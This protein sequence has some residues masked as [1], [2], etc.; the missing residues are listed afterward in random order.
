M[1]LLRVSGSIDYLSCE[2]SC[3]TPSNWVTTT[4]TPPLG[5]LASLDYDQS[6]YFAVDAA[7]QAALV[8]SAVS[9]S[10]LDDGTYLSRCT[11][12]CTVAGNW[13]RTRLSTET[14]WF[15]PHL[16][17]LPSGALAISVVVGIGTAQFAGY[18]ECPATG[19]CADISANGANFG[20]TGDSHARTS[21]A[22]DAQGRPRVAILYG[23]LG[24]TA[25]ALQLWS[26]DSACTTPANW[27]FIT[28]PWTATEGVSYTRVS[29]AFDSQSRA[30][31]A[32]RGLSSAS[33]AR[34]SSN[35]AASAAGWTSSVI[36]TSASLDALLPFVKPCAYG[37]WVFDD[38]H[39]EVLASSS[40]A[41]VLNAD[42]KAITTGGLCYGVGTFEWRSLVSL[43]Q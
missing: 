13:T 9:S 18:F 36:A 40:G 39:F 28:L 21:V 24:P 42:I 5:A 11:S 26:C 29:L 16:A 31:L 32:F 23:E 6:D 43:L 1:T 41:P 27:H 30:L 15:D 20:S 34:C 14:L 7:G 2:G 38:G 10:G 17:F 8:Y 19:A 12:A 35:C 3:L 25:Y 33:L 4:V 37:S 22:F